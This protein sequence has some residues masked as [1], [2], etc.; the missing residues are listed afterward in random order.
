VDKLHSTSEEF[1]THQREQA[2][3]KRLYTPRILLRDL[4]SILAQPSG[5]FTSDRSISPSFS[6]RIMLAVTAVNDCRYCSYGHAKRALKCGVTPEEI[7]LLLSGDVGHV[8]AAEAPAILFAQHYAE[9]GGNPDPD[10]VLTLTETY[11]KRTAEGILFRIR[12]ITL[13]NLMGNTFDALLGRLRG[14]PAEHSSVLNEV[15]VLALIVV[16]MPIMGL[17]LM[18]KRLAETLAIRSVADAA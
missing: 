10:A 1:M 13:G 6:E 11:G 2:F 4:R 5:A 3:S 7:E 18:V 8:P 9:S 16:G 12:M 17:G 14:H 15:V